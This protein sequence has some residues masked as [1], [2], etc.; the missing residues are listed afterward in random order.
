[1]LILVELK[2]S[3]INTCRSVDSEGVEFEGQRGGGAWLARR[4]SILSQR[5]LNQDDILLIFVKDKL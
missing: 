1:V 3:G 2:W 5:I 4:D